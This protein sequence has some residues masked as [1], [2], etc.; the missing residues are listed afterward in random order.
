MQSC[1]WLLP[2][3]SIQ[4]FD[5]IYTYSSPESSGFLNVGLYFRDVDFSSTEV[6]GEIEE[7]V[8]AMVDIPWITNQPGF[9]WLRDLN[10]L[11]QLNFQNMGN[12]TFNDQVD[13]FLN[14]EPYSEIYKRDIVRDENGDVVASRCQVV[15]D[16]TSLFDV[17]EQIQSTLDQR[18]VS[19]AQPVNKGK[20]DWAFFAFG[21]IF[22]A[23]ELYV[24]IV[25][26]ILLN[27]VYGL[28]AVSTIMLIFIP[29]PIGALL[30]T[31]VVAAIYCELMA[32]LYL[33]DVAVNGVS[34]IG[35]VMSIGLVVDYNGE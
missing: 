26:E 28:I 12:L 11:V 33:A 21:M 31:P 30:L 13:I 19:Q 32:V 15:F 23:W 7:Y 8:N 9:F 6:Q 20:S 18:E 1:A 24:V 35:L 3:F 5:A 14:T 29:H 4:Y 22:Y 2:L 34:A 25:H 10:A 27:V 17:N 16:Q